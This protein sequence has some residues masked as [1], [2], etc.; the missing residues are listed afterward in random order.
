MRFVFEG[1]TGLMAVRH[2]TDFGQALYLG[3][4]LVFDLD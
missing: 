4:G 2:T 1:G 3:V